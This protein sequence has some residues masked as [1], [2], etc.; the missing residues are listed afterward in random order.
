MMNRR[1]ITLFKFRGLH[2]EILVALLFAAMPCVAQTKIPYDNFNRKFLDQNLWY[3]V[4]A[5]FSVT[6]NCST[7]IHEGHLH[8]S[9]GLMGNSDSNSDTNGGSATAFFIGPYAI[10]SIISDI[11]VRDVDDIP[12]PT[13]NLDF[14]GHADIVA[15]FFNSGSANVNDDVG[16]TLF[17]GRSASDPKGQLSVMG[18]YF[19]NGDYSHVVWLTSIA[20]G[21]P[22]TVTLTWDQPNHRFLYSV[23][24]RVTHITNSGLLAYPF[25]DT[26]PAVDGEKHLDVEIFPANC[27]SNQTWVRVDALFDNVYVSQ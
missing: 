1:N 10:N 16:A 13:N 27:T 15:R 5:G 14:G 21:T 2:R 22:V 9:R 25:S 11:L 19:S 4:C 8:L 3:S 18:N 26:T 6:E 7:D 20:I 24:N 17:I 12:C 23:T